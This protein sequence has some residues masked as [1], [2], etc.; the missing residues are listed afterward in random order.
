MRANREKIERRYATLTTRNQIT[1]AF[2]KFHFSNA[3]SNY[4]RPKRSKIRRLI[5][6][7]CVYKYTNEPNHGVDL[8]STSTSLSLKVHICGWRKLEDRSFTDFSSHTAV[9]DRLVIDWRQLEECTVL[10]TTIDCFKIKA[11]MF[12]CNF[13]CLLICFHAY[14][15]INV[16]VLVNGSSS[17]GVEGGEIISS[18]ISKLVL[19]EPRPNHWRNHISE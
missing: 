17:K 14:I 8:S 5:S 9:L 13:S 2:H 19:H 3:H 16:L 12:S 7:K 10:I 4:Q 6:S 1:G 11:G 18:G 15:R